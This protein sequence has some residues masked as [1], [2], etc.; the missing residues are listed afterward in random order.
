M[1]SRIIGKNQGLVLIV[2]ILSLLACR[3]DPQGGAPSPD[4]QI[5]PSYAT[6]S[7]RER[8]QQA[9]AI[10]LAQVL[11]ISLTRW[12][13]NSGQLWT[14]PSPEAP[15]R[16]VPLPIHT[17]TLR[18]KRVLVAHGSLPNSINV[19]VLGQSPLEEPSEDYKLRIGDTIMAFLWQRDL[20]W[21]GGTRLVWMFMGYP[22]AS[23]LRERPDGTWAEDVFDGPPEERRPLRWEELEAQI[24]ALRSP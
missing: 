22:A 13:S 21:E 5:H 14:P 2:G 15:D 3:H 24:R 6:M 20:I 11:A 17:V 1:A 23:Y 18:P 12:N 9:D 7:R 16:S 4:M 19:V 10:V 8:I